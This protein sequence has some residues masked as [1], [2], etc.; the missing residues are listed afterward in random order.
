MAGFWVTARPDEGFEY[1]LVLGTSA[2]ILAMLG[3]GEV[4]IDNAIGLDVL[5]DGWIGLGAGALGIAGAAAQLATFYRP[6]RN[7]AS[8]T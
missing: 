5:L 1:V 2:V 4:S 7:R 8:T 3:P 6:D